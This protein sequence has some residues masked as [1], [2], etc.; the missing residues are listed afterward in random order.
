MSADEGKRRHRALLMVDEAHSIGVL[1]ETGRGIGEHYDVDRADVDLWMGTL[2][3]SFAS[4]GGHIAGSESLIT[5]YD[6]LVAL[7][8]EAKAK[9]RLVH[10]QPGPRQDARRDGFLAS[11]ARVRRSMRGA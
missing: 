3:K 1:G 2:S 9:M 7:D 8:A 4:S 6:E 10:Y 11:C 5:I